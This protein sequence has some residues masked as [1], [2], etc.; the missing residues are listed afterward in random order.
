MAEITR[1][2]LASMDDYELLAYEREKH[3]N[4]YMSMAR[5]EE[6]RSIALQY[7]HLGR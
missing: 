7:W 4:P 6:L 3:A 2:R 5:A 1:E